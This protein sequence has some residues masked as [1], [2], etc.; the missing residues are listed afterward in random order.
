[1]TAG[2]MQTIPAKCLRNQGSEHQFD[3]HCTVYYCFYTELG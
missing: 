3:A 2:L 1:M